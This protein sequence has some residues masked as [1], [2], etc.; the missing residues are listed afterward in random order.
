LAQRLEQLAEPG[1]VCIQDAAYQTVPKRLPF[2]YEN[3][4]ERVLKG[5]DDPVRVFATSMRSGAPAPSPERRS[6]TWGSKSDW[7][8]AVVTAVAIVI[9]AGV[10]LAWWQ[11]WL[12]REEPASVER[13]AFPLPD[14]PSIAVLPFTNMSG[15]T[16]QEYFVDG[17][18]EDLI[19]DLSKLSGLFVIARNS[20]FTYKGKSVKVGQ[21]A[22]ELGVR[23]VLEGSVR[24]VGDQ[25]R[26]NAQLIDAM[27]GG[28]VWAERY[29]MA[30]SDVFAVQDKVTEEIVGALAISLPT[31]GEAKG[32]K[33]ETVDPRAYDAFL[34]G[35]VL[36]RGG[37]PGDLEKAVSYFENAIEL[38]PDY[39]RAYAALA[40]VYW[41]AVDRD[42]SSG[43]TVWSRTLGADTDESRRREQLNLENALK[44][45]TPL[46]Y[47]VAA[48]RFSRQGRH[49]EAIEYAR[50]AIA[51]D[52]SDPVG[53][54]AMAIALIYAGTPDEADTEIRKAM[55]LDPLF[56]QKYLYWLGLAQLGMERYEDAAESLSRAAAGN[57]DD[58]SSLIVLAAVY[59]HMGRINDAKSAVG[60]ANELRETKQMR[61]TDPNLQAGIDMLLAGPYTLKDI[62]LWP[63]NDQ[64]ERD[65]LREGLRLAG[66]PET[67]ESAKHSP[68]E[69]T[70]ATTVDAAAAKALF[71][72]GVLFVDVRGEDS[73]KSGHIPKSIHLPLKRD[74]NKANL[75][76]VARADREVVMYCMGPRCL[77]SSQACSQAV[78]WGFQNVYYFR[79]GFP[80]WKAAGYPIEVQD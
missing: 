23:Y 25:V 74:F 56:A 53:H 80:G 55:R 21:V 12:P 27:T 31:D 73:W 2:E 72:R 28:H 26:I 11:P 14:K 47:Q 32:G 71:D 30:F 65:R 35:W 3:L 9:V 6:V 48:G 64:K 78:A 79:D 8:T 36:Y 61:F 54:E 4:G 60:K 50:R 63:F 19:T 43:T 7:R 70:G 34:R 40:A 15:D 46:A 44:N 29:D 10:A 52:P 33:P 67:G 77:L 51:L 38:D 41:T 62:D 45:P 69:I 49:E 22:E 17:M 57:P 13:M 24:R 42:R 58:D 18:T 5:F 16:E 68:L 59:G 39:S 20:V 76:A 1:G 66:V 75:S 37:T